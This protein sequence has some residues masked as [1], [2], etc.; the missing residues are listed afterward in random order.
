[1]ITNKNDWRTGI[2][3]RGSPWLGN[4]CFSLVLGYGN[5]DIDSSSGLLVN[6]SSAFSDFI[7]L[8]Y[9]QTRFNRFKSSKTNY[10]TQLHESSQENNGQFCSIIKAKKFG[11][12]GKWEDWLRT[13][14]AVTE[15]LNFTVLSQPCGGSIRLLISGEHRW[16]VTCKV[17]NEHKSSK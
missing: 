1:M 11:K 5:H 16:T 8:M 4:V 6:K 17:I 7:L 2:Q 9:L 14:D 12:H 13:T 15:K 3:I 10:K